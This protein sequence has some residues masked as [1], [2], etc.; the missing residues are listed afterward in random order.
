MAMKYPRGYVPFAHGFPGKCG[1]VSS[2]AVP[3]AI[4]YVLGS[5]ISYNLGL[6]AFFFSFFHFSGINP[7]LLLFYIMKVTPLRENA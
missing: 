2:Y 3:S 5:H 4:N 7:M 6:F 1:G